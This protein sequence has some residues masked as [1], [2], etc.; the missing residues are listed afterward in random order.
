[1]QSRNNCNTGNLQT[2]SVESKLSG[3]RGDFIFRF[4]DPGF[5]ELFVCTFRILLKYP[6]LR[7]LR[8]AHNATSNTVIGLRKPLRVSLACKWQKLIAWIDNVTAERRERFYKI[9]PHVRERLRS[10]R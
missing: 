4:V 8:V 7:V 2:V 10:R 6:P 5:G 3:V 9:T 1:L